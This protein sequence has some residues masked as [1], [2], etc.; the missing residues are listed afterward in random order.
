MTKQQQPTKVV[1]GK[2]RFSYLHA[3]EP[4][5]IN[6]SDPKYSV[7]LIIP[8]ADKD[9]VAKIERAIETAMKDGETRLWGGKRPANLKV[10]LRDGDAERP[11]D[12]AYKNAYFLNAN[13]KQKPG[14][15]DANLNE[16]LDSTELYSGCYG[17]AS[18][19]FFPFNTNGNK[20]V[21][22]GWNNL[23][24]LSQGDPLGGKTR[25]QDDFEAVGTEDDE[26]IDFL[27]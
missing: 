25:P 13:S 1:T 15:V 16:I 11:D 26:D 27:G 5:S 23:Q 18:V 7:S 8:K 6:G 21:G 20:G 22:V 10:P 14:I 3:F 19:N 2:V 12:E 9:T 24:L 17:R 4:K